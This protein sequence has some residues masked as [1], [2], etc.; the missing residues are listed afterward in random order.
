M[1]IFILLVTAALIL[2]RCGKKT[3]IYSIQGRLFVSSSHP[4]PIRNYKL[5][6]Y[7]SGSPSIPIPIESA[8]S[9]ATSSTN[10]EGY[11][12]CRFQAGEGSFLLIPFSNSSPLNMQGINDSSS[13]NLFWT[14]IPA[15]DTILE[16]G[17]LFKKINKAIIKIRSDIEILPSDTL[18]IVAE[19]VSGRYE[20]LLTGLSIPSNTLITADTISQL[21]STQ[22]DVRQKQYF[23]A[24]YCNNLSHNRSHNNYTYTAPLD[25]AER[26]FLIVLQ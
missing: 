5:T 1:K 25:E 24:I 26:E 9:K 23:F 6:F 10:S 15:K 21:I 7:Q 4:V 3:K 8:S 22:F 17:F 13:V 11:F 2:A 12:N 19:T 20:K 16:N 14:N 18:A